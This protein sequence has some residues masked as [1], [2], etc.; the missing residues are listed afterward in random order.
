M[1]VKQLDNNEMIIKIE[2]GKNLYCSYC[3]EKFS[4]EDF[5]VIIQYANNK[6]EIVHPECR[7][8]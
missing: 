6:T 8:L 3:G 7:G 2:S 5:A 1:D 4:R